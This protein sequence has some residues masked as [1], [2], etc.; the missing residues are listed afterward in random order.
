M[1]KHIGIITGMVLLALFCSCRNHND[2]CQDA[3]CFVPVRGMDSLFDGVEQVIYRSGHDTHNLV[4]CMS[5]QNGRRCN[6]LINQK[7]DDGFF[8]NIEE[9]KISPDKRFLNKEKKYFKEEYGCGVDQIKALILFC[10][11][12]NF[13][14]ISQYDNNICCHTNR[15]V[16]FFYSK[17]TV[18]LDEKKYKNLGQNWFTPITKESAGHELSYSPKR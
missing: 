10:R 15:A 12:N 6:I 18:F 14:F 7:N 9:N 2:C 8:F 1:N 13:V 17:D 5:F 3:I 4:Y 16:L 11:K